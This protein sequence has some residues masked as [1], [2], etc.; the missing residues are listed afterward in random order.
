[1]ALEKQLIV[2]DL[3]YGFDFRTGT[4]G[5]DPGLVS[6]GVVDA[7]IKVKRVRQRIKKRIILKD[8]IVATVEHDEISFRWLPW[9]GG[10]INYA[11]LEGK[12]VLSGMFTGC[13]MAVYKESNLRVC[14]IATQTDATDCKKAWREHTALK[15]VSEVKEFLPNRG[16]AGTFNLG[17]V[18][19]S[20]SLYKIQLEGEK[21]IMVPNPWSTAEDWMS[22]DKGNK[23]RDVAEYMA[24]LKEVNAYDIYNVSGY[25]VLKIEGPLAAEKFPD[26]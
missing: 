1:M 16:L 12:D 20:S 5:G 25:R 24:K 18:T 13:W 4:S 11:N 3:L 14:H 2:G 17:L 7:K 21:T 23:K 26:T 19:S 10:K 22:A 8:K 9:V 15:S 6:V